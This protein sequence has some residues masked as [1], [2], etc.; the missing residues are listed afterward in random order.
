MMCAANFSGLFAQGVKMDNLNKGNTSDIGL[1]GAATASGTAGQFSGDWNLDQAW[2]RE[3]F[4]D[5]PYVVADRNFDYYEPG[6]RFGYEAATRYRGKRF[7]DVEPHL[8]TDYD[9]FEHRGKST[10]ESMKDAVHD[11]F[12]K[13]TGK[14]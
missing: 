5:R 4:R 11:A 8:R 2:W 14:R 7:D 13:V 9:R 12:D 3:N 10:W 6:Y 1:T